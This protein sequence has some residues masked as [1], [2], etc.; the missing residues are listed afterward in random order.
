[1]VE[2]KTFAAA[3]RHAAGTT[4]LAAG[5]A[6]ALGGALVGYGMLETQK[7]GLRRET[8]NILPRGAADI[9]VLHLSD[10]HM[11]PGQEVKIQWL[12]ELADLKPDFV[13]NT[14][15]NL[16]HRD[17][18]PP[19]LRALEPLMAF[20]GAFVPG[21]N[22]YYA[23]K[24][25]NP[26]K[27]FA[28]TNGIPNPASRDLLAFE[29]MHRAF[30]AAGW[31]N[32]SNRSHSTVLNGLRLDLTGVD[33]P[34]IDRDHFAG[35]PRGSSTSNQAPHVR[36]AL[37]HAPYQRVL[38]QF[39]EAKADVIFAGHTHGGQVCIPGYGALVSNCDLPTWRARGLSDWEYAGNSVP[40]NVSAGLG[41]SRF[42]PIRF[43]CPPEAI[44]VTLTGRN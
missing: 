23:P 43:A 38:D 36:I 9:K 28:R 25:K 19:L 24:L 29:V 15:D 8:L 2:H 14:G 44:L 18:I 22:C 27:Y 12:R 5:G 39:T 35:W 31:V 7:F 41:T 1:M 34:H 26:F 13:I 42:A 33:D 4:A 32:M 20:P 11:I 10:I 37:T 3:L 40:L 17:G 16:S 30:G 21:S 6:L